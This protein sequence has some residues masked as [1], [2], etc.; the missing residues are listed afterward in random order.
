MT[1]TLIETMARAIAAM[2]S[3]KGPAEV[4]RATW[5]RLNEGEREM[6]RE[7]ARAAIRKGA[8]G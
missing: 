1:D 6:F 5:D 7:Q 8:E 4:N 3:L 2:W